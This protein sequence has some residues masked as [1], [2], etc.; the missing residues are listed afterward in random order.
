[1]EIRMRGF[2]LTH[3]GT[4]TINIIMVYANDSVCNAGSEKQQQCELERVKLL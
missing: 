3:C 2:Y 4:Q 1:M